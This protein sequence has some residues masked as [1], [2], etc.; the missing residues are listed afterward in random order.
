MAYVPIDDVICVAMRSNVVWKSSSVGR[1]LHSRLAYDYDNDVKFYPSG[2]QG[3]AERD[4]FVC[5][6]IANNNQF[7]INFQT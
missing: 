3:A 5:G 6:V 7:S 2:R 1:T 4:G